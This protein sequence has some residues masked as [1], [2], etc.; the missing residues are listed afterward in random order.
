[1]AKNVF[2]IFVSNIFILL[3]RLIT[4]VIIARSLGPSLVGKFFLLNVVALTLVKI[5]GMGINISN[6][7]L[8]AKDKNKFGALNTYSL[9]IAFGLG[10]VI[11]LIYLLLQGV[12]QNTVLVGVDPFLV[13][14]VILGIPF[15]LY[16][17]YWSSLM[18]GLNRIVLIN[19]FQII[20]NIISMIVYL[21][22]LLVLKLGLRELIITTLVII[23]LNAII[24]LLFSILKDKFRIT[25]DNSVLKEMINLGFKSHLGNIAHFIFLRFDYFIINPLIGPASLGYYGIAT[26]WAERVWMAIR[27][28]YTAALPRIVSST[29]EESAKIVAKLMRVLIFV[30]T[31]LSVL[32]AFTAPYF[33]NFLYGKEF[34]PA[35]VPMIILLVGVVLFGSSW[36]MGLFFIG[37]LKRPEVTGLV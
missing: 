29:K 17:S 10:V 36:F 26:N 4:G 13:T 15:T 31:I 7:T 11:F 6:S 23:A 27:P 20:S 21:F 2:I 1:M 12:L 5:L 9:F 16:S 34:L 28:V 22:I 19:V 18:L 33:I 24:L 35:V 8:A 25:F 32:F 3:I 30:M 37:Q 14:L